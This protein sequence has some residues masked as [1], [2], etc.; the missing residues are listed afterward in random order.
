MRGTSCETSITRVIYFQVFGIA[1]FREVA[2]P[3]VMHTQHC[4]PS[5]LSSTS[6]ELKTSV[7]RLMFNA[8]RLKNLP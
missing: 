8:E 2:A 4:N 6:A 5:K 7:E 1:S 3:A